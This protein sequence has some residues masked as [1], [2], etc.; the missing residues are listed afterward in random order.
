MVPRAPVDE[1]MMEQ[2]QNDGY[3][4]EDGIINRVIDRIFKDRNIENRVIGR[5]IDRISENGEVAM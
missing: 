1:V 5:V 2:N 4:I 3:L